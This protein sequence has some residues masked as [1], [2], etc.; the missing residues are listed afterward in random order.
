MGSDLKYSSQETTA[1][2]PDTKTVV[3]IRGYSIIYDR[4]GKFA[5]YSD[6]EEDIAELRQHGPSITKG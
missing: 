4:F 3:Q 1:S 6:D 2:S 5:G